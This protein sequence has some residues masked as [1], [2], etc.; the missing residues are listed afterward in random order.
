MSERPRYPRIRHDAFRAMQAMQAYVNACGLEDDL[1]ELVKLRVSYMNGCAF[2][3]DM[4]TKDARASGESEQRLF[5]LPLW[6]ETPY[7][8]ARER[9]ALD[10]AEAVAGVGGSLIPDGVYGSAREHFRDEELVDLT[11]AV[12]AIGGWNRLNVAF[13][14]P[15]GDYEPSSS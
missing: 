10:W 13:R 6:R 1:L 2:C 3:V 12:I 9:A 14:T 15:V 11:M 7:F 5:G 4:H 8:T